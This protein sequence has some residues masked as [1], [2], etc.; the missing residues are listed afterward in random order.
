MKAASCSAGIEPAVCA[1]ATHLTVYH[2]AAAPRAVT[3]VTVLAWCWCQ[4][5]SYMREQGFHIASP[6]EVKLLIR[7]PLLS[8][9]QTRLTS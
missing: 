6:C 4:L 1:A 9:S 7:S 8:E 5:A 2:H 3:F